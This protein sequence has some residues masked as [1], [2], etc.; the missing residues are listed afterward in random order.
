MTI[1]DDELED[2]DLGLS[3]DLPEDPRARRLGAAGC[4]AIV[5]GVGAVALVGCAP[6]T[7]RHRATTP[8]GRRAG[9]PAARRR[10]RRGRPTRRRRRRGRDPRGDRRPL[11]GRRLQR[12]QRAHRERRR[13]QRHHHQ[14]RLGCPAP[15]RA[16]RSPSGS[17]S[18]TSTA[19][20]DARSPA[21]RSTCGTA[22]GEGGYSMYSEGVTDENYLRGVQEA[23]ADGSLSSRRSSRPAY[24]GR[25]P[26][27]HF[28]VYE[29]L[30]A[31][32]ACTGKLRTSQLAL[33]ADVCEQVYGV[34]EGYD[35]SVIDLRASLAR[36]RHGLQRR[37]LAAAGDGHRARSTRATRSASTCL[38]DRG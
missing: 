29:S 9:P 24:D 13:A 6:T 21:P 25:W 38:S 4:S 8:S 35:A 11:P 15:P 23:D 19:R 34:A 36:H 18:T 3:H 28:E 12:A 5:G 22:T 33:P 37:L 26:H 1:A 16:S 32:P 17:R 20:R 30:D 31:R 2:H 14:L 27:M 7:R 10:R